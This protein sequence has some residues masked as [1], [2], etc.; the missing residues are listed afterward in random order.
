MYKKLTVLIFM[1]ISLVSGC[2]AEGIK[3]DSGQGEEKPK[4]IAEG[5]AKVFIYDRWYEFHQPKYDLKR[6]IKD[7]QGIGYQDWVLFEKKKVDAG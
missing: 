1:F 6:S 5:W 2:A 3:T 4:Y 7:R